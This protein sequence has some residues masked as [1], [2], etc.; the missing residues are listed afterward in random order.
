MASGYFGSGYYA[1]GYYDSG[2]YGETQPV[3]PPLIPDEIP[4][5]GG[6]SMWG[7]DEAK[8]ILDDDKVIMAV[9]KQFLI[10]VN[11]EL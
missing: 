6:G 2:Y 3:I 10:E 7:R 1:S 11:L 9:I 5:G 8:R 4:G